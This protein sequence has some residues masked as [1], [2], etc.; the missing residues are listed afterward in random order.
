MFSL[1]S[2][3]MCKAPVK[4]QLAP[5]RL[6]EIQHLPAAFI[7]SIFTWNWYPQKI[8]PSYST[9]LYCSSVDSLLLNCFV[10]LNSAVGGVER[11]CLPVFFS[12]KHMEQICR[13]ARPRS[14]TSHS[15]THTQKMVHTSGLL[16][17]F[18][19][20]FYSSLSSTLLYRLTLCTLS[21]TD[22][23]SLE[24]T[25]INMMMLYMLKQRTFYSF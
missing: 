20:C 1:P 5:Y 13:L 10:F 3:S 15:H 8:R 11:S 17:L 2:Q 23:V 7:R 24:N 12:R 18:T 19:L 4:Q 9:V 22:V 21:C 14:A 16:P 6:P 25:V